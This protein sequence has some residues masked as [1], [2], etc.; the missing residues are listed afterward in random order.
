MI[1]IKFPG[2]RRDFVAAYNELNDK[3]FFGVKG[4][5]LN[6]L[7]LAD[8]IN[9]YYKLGTIGSVGI[10]FTADE[11]AFIRRI[12]NATSFADAAQIAEDLFKFCSEQQH[13]Q[14][15]QQQQGNPNKP[16]NGGQSQQQQNDADQQ[17]ADSDSDDTQDGSNNTGD[18]GNEQRDGGS[19]D[20]QDQGKQPADQKQESKDKPKSAK[21]VGSE[22]AQ[23]EQ[24]P[25]TPTTQQMFN[26]KISQ[27][28]QRDA[29][30]SS[31]NAP[32]ELVHCNLDKIVIDCKKI[33]EAARTDAAWI[34]NQIGRAHV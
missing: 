1:Q 25:P 7:N 27:Q 32:T 31:V 19:D 11:D 33:V 21:D 3:N 14:Q 8:R 22:S 30:S 10:N 29:W 26:E 15:P 18:R 13:K 16:C 20:Q 5:N 2:F 9:L 12:D 34:F 28:V 6:T 4:Q 23:M 24:A 17:T